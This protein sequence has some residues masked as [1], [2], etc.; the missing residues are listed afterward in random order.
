[1]ILTVNIGNTNLTYALYDQAIVASHKTYNKQYKTFVTFLK[2]NKELIDQAIISSVVP[3]KNQKIMRDIERHLNIKPKILT[4]NFLW[5]FSLDY[6]EGELGIDRLL[7]TESAYR[8][9]KKA[10]ILF[11]LGTA[12]TMNV[13]SHQQVFLGGLILPGLQLGFKALKNAT[14]LLPDIEL[15]SANG[16]LGKNTKENMLSGAI[17]GTAT[18]IDGLVARVNQAYPDDYL[19]II[20]GGHAKYVTPHC[21]TTHLVDEYLILEGLVGIYNEIQ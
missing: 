5:S 9:Y 21:Q 7:A 4:R 18:L 12:T 3:E 8:K 2:T 15:E 6:A 16:I 10:V 13:L 19:V 20:T 1:M 14:A 11:D 17:H